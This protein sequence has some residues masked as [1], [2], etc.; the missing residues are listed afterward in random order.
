MR[1][2][3]AA[4]QQ[5][6]QL[7]LRATPPVSRLCTR[8]L[9]IRCAALLPDQPQQQQQQPAR[10]AD[11]SSNPPGA[12]ALQLSPDQQ[13][14][15]RAAVVAAAACCVFASNVG[16]ARASD[17]WM[18]R[19]HHR[20]IGE[21]FTDTWADSIVEVCVLSQGGQTDTQAAA[22]VEGRVRLQPLPSLRA[23]NPADSALFAAAKRPAQSQGS[24]L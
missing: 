3:A 24:S 17:S 18:P 13:A 10:S 23:R 4:Q 1:A 11:S 5:Q 6:L 2:A 8:R 21:R 19:R 15:L 20:H 16:A 14:R 12:A 9:S 22:A 7:P